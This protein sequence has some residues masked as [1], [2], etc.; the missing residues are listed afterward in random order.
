MKLEKTLILGSNGFVGQ[1]MEEFIKTHHEESL[2]SYVFHKGKNELDIKDASQLSKYLKKHKPEVIVNLTAFVG[3]ISYGYEFPA[4]ILHEN[5][6]MIL[7]LFEEARINGV[8]KIVSPISNCAYPGDI[9]FYTEEKFWEGKPHESVFN[10]AFSRRLSVA[11]S[12]SYLKQY[13]FNSSSVVLSNMYGKYDH[14]E[15][16]R[17]HALGAIVNKIYEAK[18]KQK[19]EVSIW[20]TGKPIREWLYVE[21]GVKALLKSTKLGSGHHFFNVGVNKGISIKDLSEKIANII[22]WHGVFKFDLTKPDGALEKRV[23]GKNMLEKL[24]W[25]P[26]TSLDDGLLKTID[27]YVRKKTNI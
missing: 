12:I 9:N 22:G 14:F 25:E 11:M 5:S 2:D 21:D 15:E 13:N 20:G 27:W 10:Y 1:N 17:S 7:N 4:K 18:V 23:D 19:K 6:T 24:S 16:K 3:G 26:E 8:R